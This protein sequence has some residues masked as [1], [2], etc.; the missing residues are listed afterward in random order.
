MDGL[1]QHRHCS[2]ILAWHPLQILIKGAQAAQILRPA[3][4][5]PGEQ[6]AKG[7]QM[8]HGQHRQVVNDKVRVLLCF[9]DM[10]SHADVMVHDRKE[11]ALAQHDTLAAAGGAGGEHEH[12]QRLGVAV[13]GKLSGLT[14]S[15]TVHGPQNAA[16]SRL[17]FGI[18]AVVLAIGQ[19]GGRLHQLQL[20]A[21]L[22]PALALVQRHYNTARQHDAIAVDG[23]CVAVI[24]PQADTLS[25]D[26][27]NSALEIVHCPADIL[28]TFAVGPAAHR[29]GRFVVP[30]ES[31]TVCKTPF[32]VPGDQLIK[33]SGFCLVHDHFLFPTVTGAAACL[34]SCGAAAV[35]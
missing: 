15:K 9:A 8:E 25:A 23:V 18:A 4:P 31:C 1:H 5:W 10:M 22:V 32:H 19:D 35:R 21:Q 20:I 12:H 2:H 34:Q 16:I 14:G 26:L 6:A 11:I 33:V 13:I 3:H 24:A 17:H 29:I 27:R 7:S 30:A 28:R